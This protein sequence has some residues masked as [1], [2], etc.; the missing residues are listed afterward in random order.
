MTLVRFA[1]GFEYSS[2]NCTI[3]RNGQELTRFSE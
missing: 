3:K 2:L 1:D